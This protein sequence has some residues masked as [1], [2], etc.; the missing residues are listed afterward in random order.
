MRGS[1]E[2]R[3]RSICAKPMNQEA[4]PQ[5]REG[6]DEMCQPLRNLLQPHS[7]LIL[8]HVTV[9]ELSKMHLGHVTVIN[10]IVRKTIGREQIKHACRHPN[11]THGSSFQ[12]VS[13]FVVI[14]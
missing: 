7:T 1:F 11:R 9:I 5:A 14:S 8:H 10:Y 2:W 12:K 6:A 3:Q 13:A 4:I